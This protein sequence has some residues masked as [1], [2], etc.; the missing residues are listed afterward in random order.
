M[1]R[2]ALRVG[3]AA[4]AAL[5]LSVVMVGT[6]GAVAGAHSFCDFSTGGQH[7]HNVIELDVRSDVHN[8]G[9]PT[10]PIAMRH[11]HY[12]PI[13]GTTYHSWVYCSG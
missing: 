1:R 3:V 4:A 2:L 11:G 6:Q 5:S 7:T 12:Y 10:A 9:P 13:V 8:G